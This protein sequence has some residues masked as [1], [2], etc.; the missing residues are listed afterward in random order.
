MIEPKL[1]SLPC[2][3]CGRSV[4]VT[5]KKARE[6]LGPEWQGEPVLEYV[7]K[8][9]RQLETATGIVREVTLPKCLEHSPEYWDGVGN[10]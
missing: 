5:L 4:E 7:E 3:V 9:R 10:D 2:K 6:Y 8:M 1:I